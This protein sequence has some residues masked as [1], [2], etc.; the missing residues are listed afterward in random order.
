LLLYHTTSVKA[1]ERILAEGFRDGGMGLGFYRE[2]CLPAALVT[3]EH[4]VAIDGVPP[5]PDPLLN[6]R[7]RAAHV[8]LAAER[9]TIDGPLLLS[10][11]VWPTPE[12]ERASV[13]RAAGSRAENP[14]PAVPARAPRHRGAA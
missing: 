7:A 1:A 2:W 9:Q 10:F 8:V 6:V 5:S 13:V 11:V 14:K 4:V 12:L 3:L